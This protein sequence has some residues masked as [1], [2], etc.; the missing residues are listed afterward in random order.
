MTKI[1]VSK[2]ILVISIILIIVI[3]SVG[4]IAATS[5]INL[6]GPQGPQGIQGVPG[7]SGQPGSKGDTGSDGPAGA[8]GA[9]GPAG[10]TGSQGPKGDTGATGQA[11]NAT[12]Y[13]IEGSF[14]TS[15]NG[16]LTQTSYGTTTHW[17]RISI[18]QLTLD[19]MPSIEVY[20][21]STEPVNVTID[22]Q[23][24]TI[25][26]WVRFHQL[27]GNPDGIIYDQGALY[28]YYKQ[29]SGNSTYTAITGDYK[30]VVIK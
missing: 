7:S 28:L 27:I 29:T 4:T 17:K 9:T 12:R 24:T 19:D 1:T 25:Q 8:I 11:G 22:G 5:L 3:S 10:A 30:V 15:Q 21:R 16:D 23:Q 26:P 14:N 13:V 20:V 2:I 18:P 6:Q